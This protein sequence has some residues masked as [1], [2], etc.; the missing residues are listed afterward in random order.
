M[1]LKVKTNGD[2]LVTHHEHAAIRGHGQVKSYIGRAWDET[3][4]AWV[5]TG[6]AV[7]VPTCNESD[8]HFRTYWNAYAQD[9]RE[10]ALVAADTETAKACG[11]KASTTKALH[12]DPTVHA[13]MQS[14]IDAQSAADQAAA[15]AAGKRR[16]ADRAAAIKR[17]SDAAAEAFDA[18]T[19]SAAHAAET[20]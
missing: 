2:I 14:A 8:P 16:A 18:T 19:P 3:T 15:D 7:E 6:A 20:E 1:K 17:A 11:V 10:G 13:A 12:E 9:V 5:S 4:K